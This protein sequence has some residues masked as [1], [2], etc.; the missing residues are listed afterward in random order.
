VNGLPGAALRAGSLIPLELLLDRAKEFIVL[1][2][3]L[4]YQPVSLFLRKPPEF[5]AGQ[6]GERSNLFRESVAR[7]THR[8]M[9]DGLAH[10][11]EPEV[12]RDPTLAGSTRIGARGCPSKA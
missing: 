10:V 6:S 9:E 3:V 1:L 7:A 2:T 11:L 5:F 4:R 12:R 8:T